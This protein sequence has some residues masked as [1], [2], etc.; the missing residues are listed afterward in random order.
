MLKAIR[1]KLWQQLPNYRKPASFLV[2]ESYPLPPYSSV[3]GMIHAACGYTVYHP[4]QISIQGINA[5]EISDYATL[6]NFGI[7]Y[8]E[9]RHQA[10]VQN[11][12]GGY[13]GIN[14]SPKSIHLLTDVEILIHIFPENIDDFDDIYE[15]L[16][17]PKTYLSLGRHED[18]VRIDDISIIE[19]DEY[20]E[21]MADDGKYLIKYDIYSPVKY[22]SDEIKTGTIYN[23]TKEFKINPKTNTREWIS[24]IETAHIPRKESVR[25]NDLYYDSSIKTVVLFA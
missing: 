9:T 2:K 1:L 5:S 22:L 14:I 10:K 23:L 13:D 19:L 6:Y 4:M 21:E 11:D 25:F 16:I 17:H 18:I 12:E 7:K 15:G 24:Y 3:I 8:D 20:D